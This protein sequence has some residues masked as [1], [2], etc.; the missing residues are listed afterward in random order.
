M[1]RVGWK[2]SW[3]DLLPV[4]PR[5]VLTSL[6]T[7]SK[8]CNLRLSGFTDLKLSHSAVSCDRLPKSYRTSLAYEYKIW[9]ADHPIQ[10]ISPSFNFPLHHVNLHLLSAFHWTTHPWPKAAAVHWGRGKFKS[11]SEPPPRLSYSSGKYRCN[12]EQIYLESCS[13]AP[14]STHQKSYLQF[15]GVNGCYGS[16]YPFPSFLRAIDSDVIRIATEVTSRLSFHYQLQMLAS[17]D[18]C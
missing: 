13:I 18:F 15:S 16:F 9:R 11:A 5:Q 2:L 14:V 17:G 10:V 8:F 12:S 1:Y 4:W 3:I 7:Q 6:L